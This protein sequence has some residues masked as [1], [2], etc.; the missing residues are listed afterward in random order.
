MRK[1]PNYKN[2]N[3][4]L[5]FIICTNILLREM[6]RKNAYNSILKNNVVL[7]KNFIKTDIKEFTS[8]PNPTYFDLKTYVL[9]CLTR[10]DALH[11]PHFPF[12]L[13]PIK[14]KH[15]PSYQLWLNQYP[16]VCEHSCNQKGQ[17]IKSIASD[18]TLAYNTNSNLKI[19]SW[20]YKRPILVSW[21]LSLNCWIP[22][23]NL[24]KPI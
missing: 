6:K 18:C 15:T 21:N 24:M 8:Q 17:T 4:N 2:Q 5:L 12:I 1:I 13:S 23:Y 14:L 7:G 22:D 11:N 9:T 3:R 19:S 16:N 20:H 10:F